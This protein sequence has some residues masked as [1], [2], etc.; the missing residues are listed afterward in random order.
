MTHRHAGPAGHRE[1]TGEREPPSS[2]ELKLVDEGFSDEGKGTDRFP[3]TSR[4]A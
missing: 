3:M 2:G 1:E 4:I